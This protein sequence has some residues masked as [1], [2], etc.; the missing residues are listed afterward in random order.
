MGCFEDLVPQDSSG[1]RP[2]QAALERLQREIF[3]ATRREPGRR[4]G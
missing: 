4:D 2:E 1:V 3:A